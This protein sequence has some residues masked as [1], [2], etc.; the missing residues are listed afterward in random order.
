MNNKIRIASAILL[1]ANNDL[2]VVRKKNS[3]FYMLPGGKI[4]EG[5]ALID[6]LRRELCEELDLQFEKDDF[7]FLGVHET[8]AANEANTIVEGNIFLLKRPLL[9]DT[10]NNQAEIEEVCWITKS[11]Y[12]SF[13]LA[14]LLE[15][16]ALPRW[17]AD[18]S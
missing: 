12:K 10:V 1:N 18:F 15:E 17:L 7:A 14:H 9:V 3:L 16:F 5:E 2:L 11:N 6:T 4:E 8:A 13:Q